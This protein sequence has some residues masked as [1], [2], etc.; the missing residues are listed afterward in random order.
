VRAGAEAKFPGTKTFIPQAKAASAFHLLFEGR[1]TT[2]PRIRA[3]HIV[4]VTEADGEFIRVRE[5]FSR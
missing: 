2:Q 4:E 5:F 1:A 3:L